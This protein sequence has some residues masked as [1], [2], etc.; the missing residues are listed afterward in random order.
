MSV[1]IES[2]LN[3]RGSIS[4]NSLSVTSGIETLS[5]A[6]VA[7]LHLW[8]GSA[9]SWQL[10]STIEQTS[11]TYADYGVRFKLNN[12]TMDLRVPGL[13]YSSGI[14]TIDAKVNHLQVDGDASVDGT[15]SVEALQ[16]SSLDISNISFANTTFTAKNAAIENNLTAKTLD[17]TDSATVNFASFPGGLHARDALVSN[18]TV[19][20]ATSLDTVNVVSLL[21]APLIKARRAEFSEVYV[22]GKSI[23]GSSTGGGG[24]V[25]I[26]TDLSVDTLTA[27]RSISIP[28]TQFANGSIAIETDA[29]IRVGTAG[30]ITIADEASAPI[31]RIDNTGITTTADIQADNI[32]AATFSSGTLQVTGPGQVGGLLK[33]ADL[34]VSSSLT[35]DSAYIAG[36]GA[37]SLS[38][39]SMSVIREL[40]ASSIDVSDL[41]A[42]S[43]EVRSTLSASSADIKSIGASDL[44]ATYI[45]A[46]DL[47]VSSAK[48]DDHM[49]IVGVLSVGSVDTKHVNASSVSVTHSIQTNTLSSTSVRSTNATISQLTTDYITTSIDADVIN[50]N[51]NVSVVGSLSSTSVLS[52]NATIYELRAD[53]INANNAADAINIDGNV[54]VVGSLSS[55]SLF[56]NGVEITEN[57]GDIEIPATIKVSAVAPLQDNAPVF[58]PRIQSSQMQ[59]MYVAVGDSME[60]EGS[61]DVAESIHVEGSLYINNVLCVEDVASNIKRLEVGSTDINMA[62]NVYYFKNSA[63]GNSNLIYSYKTGTF[64]QHEFG[65]TNDTAFFYSNLRPALDKDGISSS[66][67]VQSMIEDMRDSDFDYMNTCVPLTIMLELFQLKQ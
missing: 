20:Q 61:I 57:G 44:T 39:T 40:S 16:V 66:S 17:I 38:T 15:L 30:A 47:L 33:V 64:K 37:S 11:L 42:T 41:T 32:S 10:Y 49:S 43:M 29:G 67:G 14:H 8:D 24:D 56:V 22:N 9:Y 2:D 19:L 50:I 7:G 51:G 5:E 1:H 35:A 6:K 18:L 53:R 55:T 28:G 36:L 31:V 63:A 13:L 48:V 60:V 25:T 65:N 46:N 26:P 34:N 54:S 52:D 62:T 58:V 4:A 27:N 23:I 12:G 3:V 45:T 21:H 59:V